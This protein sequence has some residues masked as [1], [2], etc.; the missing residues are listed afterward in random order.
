L[1]ALDKLDRSRQDRVWIDGEDYLIHTDFPYWIGFGKKFEQFQREGIKKFSL[2][3]LDYLYKIMKTSGGKEYGIPENR[4]KGYEELCKFYRNDQPL[5]HP[6]GKQSGIR[7]VDWL[8]DSEYIYT[9]FIQ[10][11]GID[12]ETTDMHWHKFLSLFNSLTGTK[13]NDIMSARFYKKPSKNKKEDPM[14]EMRNAWK[15]ETLD[16]FKKEIFKMR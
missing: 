15:L 16:E 12:L 2:F 3:E 14:E 9:A 6:T 1:I 8:I 4:A 11:Y 10:Q 5:P 13:L 7:G